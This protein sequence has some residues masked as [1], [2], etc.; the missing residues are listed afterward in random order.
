[1][2]LEDNKDTPQQSETVGDLIKQLDEETVEAI[3]A[4]AEAIIKKQRVKKKQG[5]KNRDKGHRVERDYATI[6]Q[7]VGFKQCKTTRATSRLMDSCKIDLNFIPILLQIKAGYEKG[8]NPAAILRQMDEELKKN[9]PAYDPIHTLPRAVLH[10]KDLPKGQSSRSIYDAMISMTFQDLLVLIV[11]FK[12]Q[13]EY[14][15]QNKQRGD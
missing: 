15:F 14:D 4:S 6:F 2:Q 8:L 13:L 1:M 3:N 10:H 9:Y 12:K 7:N 5:P 11:A